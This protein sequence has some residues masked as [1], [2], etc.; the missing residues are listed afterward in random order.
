M[1][2]IDRAGVPAD[3]PHTVARALEEDMG[4]GDVSA[5]LIPASQSAHAQVICRERAVI[6]GIAWF[7]EVFRQIDPTV[8]VAWQVTEGI[9]IEANTLLCTLS[10]PARSLLSGERTAL[11][12]LQT[13]SATATKVA[14]YVSLVADTDVVLLDTRKTLPG[15]RSAQKYAVRCGGG[16]NHRHGLYDAFLLKENHIA[17]ATSITAAVVAARALR[18]ELLLQVEVENLAQLD[19]ALAAGVERILLDNFTPTQLS[20]A[21]AHTAKRARLEASGGIT[22]ANLNAIAATGVDYISL[23]TLTKDVQAVDLSMRFIEKSAANSP[24]N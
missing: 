22:R 9:W 16:Q 2:I 17:A 24:R 12:F 13:L 7:D 21:V 5:A 23:G 15:L 20:Q 14:D 10:G 18:P 6:C 4:N 1:S 11:N 8:T 19:E 3:M